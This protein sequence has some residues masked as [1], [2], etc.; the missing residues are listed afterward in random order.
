MGDYTWEYTMIFN[1]DFSLIEDG[2]VISKDKKGNITYT[3]E[4]G[5]SKDLDYKIYYMT[6]AE[7]PEKK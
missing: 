1:E 7:K 2:Q 4:Y 5:P 6:D 3:Y